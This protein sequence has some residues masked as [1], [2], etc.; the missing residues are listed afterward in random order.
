LRTKTEIIEILKFSTCVV[1]CAGS[2]CQKMDILFPLA[3]NGQQRQILRFL[4]DESPLNVMSNAR[5]TT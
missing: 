4:D 1:E 2:A 3:L 5:G